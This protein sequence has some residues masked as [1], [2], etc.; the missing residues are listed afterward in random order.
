MVFCRRSANLWP[1]TGWS[2]RTLRQ[3]PTTS[4]TR[5]RIAPSLTSLFSRRRR[6]S[7]HW[8]PY[9]LLRSK[10][11]HVDKRAVMRR[12]PW[13]TRAAS[14]WW[15]MSQTESCRPG[16]QSWRRGAMICTTPSNTMAATA[17]CFLGFAP[18]TS[19]APPPCCESWQGPRGWC[20]VMRAACLTRMVQEIRLRGFHPGSGG[21]REHF[22]HY[23]PEDLQHSSPIVTCAHAGG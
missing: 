23:L 22:T 10:F 11:S 17:W 21:C 9:M 5:S 19:R 3:G 15:R 6:V 2:C 16:A 1:Q 20:L 8:V 13:T 4:T 14:C 12:L 18:S 7:H